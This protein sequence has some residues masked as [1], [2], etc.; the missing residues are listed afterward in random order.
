MKPLDDVHETADWY[1]WRIN[2]PFEWCVWN[3]CF[4][5]YEINDR[6]LWNRWLLYMNQL[7]DVNE[8]DKLFLLNRWPVSMKP[9]VLVMKPLADIYETADSCLWTSWLIIMTPL[10]DVTET[11][12][13]CVRNSW[14]VFMEPLSG[15]H[16]I[17]DCCLWNFWL[18]YVKPLTVVYETGDWY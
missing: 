10:T 15:V 3:R 7:N 12:N 2:E 14:L 18:V 1:L 16:E 6:C 11:A 9:P 13:Y 17:D 8:T 5:V 4:R